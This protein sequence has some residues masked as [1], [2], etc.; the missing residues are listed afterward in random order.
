MDEKIIRPKGRQLIDMLNDSYTICNKCGAVMDLYLPA[1]DETIMIC[2][3]CG[4]KVNIED[5]IYGER[6][7]EDKEWAP[8]MTQMFG[9][10]IPPAGCMACGGP[11]PYCKSSCKMFDD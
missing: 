7:Q 3:D 10:D 11:Y 6:C 2:P 1:E 9:E 8:N 4:W 5:Y